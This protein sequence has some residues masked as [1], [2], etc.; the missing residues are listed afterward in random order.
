MTDKRTSINPISAKVRLDPTK[1]FSP[2]F[3]IAYIE[4][5]FKF[6]LVHKLQWYSTEENIQILSN[7]LPRH[8]WAGTYQFEVRLWL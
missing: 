2:F 6:N 4:T 3:L 1:N 5:Q 8:K 7:I